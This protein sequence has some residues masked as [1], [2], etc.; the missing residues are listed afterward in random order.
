MNMAQIQEEIYTQDDPMSA[1]LYAL[2]A[3]ESRRQY[4]KRLK[5]LFDFLDLVEPMENPAVEFVKRTKMDSKWAHD[6]FV[7]FIS[8]Q[9]QR[10]TKG[11]IAASTISNYYKAA[12]LFCEMNDL[13]INWKRISRGMPHGRHAANDRAPTLEELHKLHVITIK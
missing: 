3:P 10:G 4:P 2:K 11:E 5:M 1:F 8:Y 13:T 12:K 9:K 6:S 7:R